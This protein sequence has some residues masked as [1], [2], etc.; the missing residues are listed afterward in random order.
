MEMSPHQQHPTHKRLLMTNDAISHFCLFRAPMDPEQFRQEIRALAG[1]HIGIFQ[2]CIGTPL[3]ARHESEVLEVRGTQGRAYENYVNWQIHA[4]LLHLIRTGNDPLRIVCEEGHR[5]GM[6]VWGSQRMNDRHHTYDIADTWCLVSPFCEEHPEALL[7]DGALNWLRPEVHERVL[8]HFREVAE[9]YDVEG[10][11]LDYTRIPPFFNP[12]E[13]VK[14]REA[15]TEFVRRARAVLDQV[16]AKKG[17]RLGLSAQLYA[18]DPLE[19]SVETAYNYGCDVRRWARE[20]LIDILIGHYRSKMAY[21]PDVSNWLAAVE[22]T[23]CKLYAGPGKPRERHC[24]MRL[25]LTRFITHEEH[26]AIAAHLHAQGVDGISFYDYMH[27]GSFDLR[28]F[29]EMGD[30]EVLRFANKLYVAQKELPLDLGCSATGGAASTMLRFSDDLEA[31]R[32]R[33]YNP[34]TRLLLNVPNLPEP[35]DVR[36]FL[37]GRDIGSPAR[38]KLPAFPF[39]DMEYEEDMAWW[40]LELPFDCSLLRLGMNEVR[41]VLSPRYEELRAPCKVMKLDL[42]IRYSDES[43]RYGEWARFTGHGV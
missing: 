22:G 10:I 9:N 32:E 24:S 15:M 38:E 41:F 11:D 27:H 8:G 42:E 37:N 40:H 39:R 33:G 34:R 25:G 6:Q 26:R 30:P 36:V 5:A 13:I 1:T 18:Q 19:N 20:G 3:T 7:P 17:K 12:D 2:W 21:E 43:A 16:G 29:Y 31:A 4:N 28:P 14:G 35:Q 23:S